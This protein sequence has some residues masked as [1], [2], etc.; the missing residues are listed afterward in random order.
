MELI[1]NRTQLIA[2]IETLERYLFKGNETEKR[3]ALSLV[4]RGICFVAY[5]VGDE[6][7]FAPSRFIGYIG[8]TIEKHQAN[9][10]KHGTF[11]NAAIKSILRDDPWRNESLEEKYFE[12]CGRLGISPNKRA[13]FNADR[14]FWKL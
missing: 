10:T 3:E 9:P 11:T 14:R 1:T 6:T 5:K 12:Y 8:N 4:K 13:P 7:R 2:N